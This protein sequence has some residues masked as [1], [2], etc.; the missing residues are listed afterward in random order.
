MAQCVSQSA[1]RE[2]AAPS[3]IFDIDPTK[4]FVKIRLLSLLLYVYDP[5]LEFKD[6]HV[7]L[8]GGG[9]TNSRLLSLVVDIFTT[10]P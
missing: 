10:V 4:N 3:P 5:G 6:G 8:Q 2:N 7:P 9:A 1:L